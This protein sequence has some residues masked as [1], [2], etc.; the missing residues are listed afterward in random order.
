M[1]T[2]P[3]RNARQNQ[4]PAPTRPEF[5]LLNQHTLAIAFVAFAVA[6]MLFVST[7]YAGT[8]ALPLGNQP[9]VAVT[10][11]GEPLAR[12]VSQRLSQSGGPSRIGIIAGH[13]NHDSGAVCADGLTEAQVNATVAELVIAQLRQRGLDAELLDE[14]DSRTQGYVGTAVISIHADSCQGPG[15]DRSGFKTSAS[16]APGA[17]LLETCIIDRYQTGTGLAYD[18]NT[19]TEDMRQYHNFNRV[20]PT[21]PA[22]IVEIG[23]MGGDRVLLTTNAATVAQALTNGIVCFVE[24]TQ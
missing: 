5:H 20:A 3:R 2:P 19:I 23:F 7:F 10:A 18:P 6:L 11:Q 9:T 22:L 1:T 4:Q 8:F 12:T 15:S 16:I 13:R 17:Q 24:Q 14:F 21:T